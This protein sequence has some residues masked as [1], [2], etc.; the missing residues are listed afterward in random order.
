ME[1]LT[2]RKLMIVNIINRDNIEN[3]HNTDNDFV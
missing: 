2:Q 3:P 1:T